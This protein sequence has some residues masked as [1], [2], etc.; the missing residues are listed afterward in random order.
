MVRIRPERRTPVDLV[1]SAAIVVILLVVGLVVWVNSTAR[2]TDSAQAA[3][4]A[5]AV[6]AATAVPARL[7]PLW[8]ARSPVT[9]TPA[10]ARSLVITADGGS[11]VGRDPTTGH[12]VWH[13]RRDL[14]L[15][16]VLA[17]WPS[18]NNEV[19]AAYRNS[20]GCG[21]VTALDGSSGQREGSRSSDADDRINLA[22]DSG[23]V[24]SQGPTR[25]ETWGS[26]LVRGIE[27]GRVDAPVKPGVQPGRTGCRLMSSTIG[28]DRVAI[29]E[30]C[31]NEPGYRL[32]VLGAVLNKDE[33][34]QQY[35]SSLIT[36]GT[37]GPPPV[38]IAMS[39][40][41]IAVY[42]GGGNR[43]APASNDAP[44][45]APAP[46]VR[47]FTTDGVPTVV[48]TV[49]GA[50][51][52]PDGAVPVTNGGLT[53]YFTGGTTVVLNAQNVHPI[54]QV[55]G[56]IGSGD[57]MAD[58]LLLPT[59]TGISVRDAATGREVRSIPVQRDGYT[60]GPI[61]LRVL[62]TTVIEQWGSTVQA[63]GPA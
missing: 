50:P 59:A 56:A 61:S 13:Y 63:Y 27:Y 62:G 19:L 21:E 20:R 34:V 28:G 26:N 24:V 43:P 37:S 52:P 7:T 29:V 6:T 18:S 35:G 33:E 12:E 15:C 17:A 8:H 53:S 16:A 30:H 57:V 5:P 42:D 48:N 22:S 60:G 41:G 58:R 45:E 3:V 1:V 51:A 36:D 55:P 11:V 9:S 31:G 14:G 40:S 23:Y 4:T 39:S 32:T 38:A 49:A 46:S 54:Y 10:I 25:L 47:Q 44:A 2:H